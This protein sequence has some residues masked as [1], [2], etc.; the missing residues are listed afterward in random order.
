MRCQYLEQLLVIEVI[1][2]IKLKYQ[3]VIHT[4]RPPAVRVDAEQEDKQSDEK[5]A[6]IHAQRWMPVHSSAVH[7]V[8]HCRHTSTAVTATFTIC[9]STSMSFISHSIM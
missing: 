2:W 9:C 6:A 3:D 1:A 5:H 4:R 7:S 8:V